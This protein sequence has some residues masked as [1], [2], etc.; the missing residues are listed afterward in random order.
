[1]IHVS[2]DYDDTLT[3]EDPVE[4]EERRGNIRFKLCRGLFLPEG[5]AGL[6]SA[7]RQLLAGGQ[8]FQLWRGEIVS[9]HS[10]ELREFKDARIHRGP[11]VDEKTGP[12]YW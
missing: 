1:M 12:R 3:F 2:Y 5:V 8:W 7:V 4:V 11:L 6:N 9:M 10:P